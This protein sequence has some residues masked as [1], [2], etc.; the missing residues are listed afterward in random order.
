M[1]RPTSV[2]VFGILNLVFAGFGVLGILGTLA[3]FRME[4]MAN[5][6]VVTLM[7]ENATYRAYMKASIPLGIVYCL[8]LLLGGIGLLRLRPWGRTL[9][10]IYALLAIVGGLLGVAMNF[11]YIFFPM[12]EQAGGGSGPGATAAMA[13]ALGGTVGGL[14]GLVYPILLLIFMTRR[15]VVAAFRSPPPP[16]LP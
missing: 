13:G 6:P 11:I 16:P 12:L 8:I 7:Q 2:T 15:K 10:I 1:Q 14:V 9:S 3:L 5:N 4:G